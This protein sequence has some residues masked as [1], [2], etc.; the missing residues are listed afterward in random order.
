MSKETRSPHIPTS[1]KQKTVE[2]PGPYVAVVRE[3]LDV[4][5]MGSLKV[6]LLKTTSEGNSESSGEFVPVSYLSPFYGVT[7]YAGTSE[8]EGYDYTQKS[9]GFWAVPPDIGTKVLVIFAEGNRGKGYWIGCVQDQNMN[10]MVPGNASTKFNKED[11]TKARPVAEYNKKTEDANGTNATQYLKP[12]H[13]DACAILDGSGL[14]D[15]PIRGT[16]TSSAR[17]DLPSM[18]FGWSSPGPIDRR[19]GTPTIKSGGK[20]DSIDLKASRLTGTTLV[21]DDGDP[22]LFR[23]G[24]ARGPNAVPSEYVSLK[25]GGNPVLP[26]NEL[27]RIRTRTGHQILLHNA[28]DLIYIAHGSG[29]SWIEMTANGKIDIYSKDSIS[30][31]TEND[32]NFKAGRDVNIEAGNN[33]NLKAGNQMMTQTAANYEVK[34]GADGKITCAGT[35]NITSKHHYETA[36]RIDMNGPPAAKA[37]DTSV[38]TRVPKRGSW[39]GQENKN[40][41]EHTP[42]KTNANLE[43]IKK[44]NANKT[45][46]D[47][48]KDKKPEDTF[49]QC[50]VPAGNENAGI[51]GPAES[52]AAENKNATLVDD[53]NGFG[54]AQGGEF[55]TTNDNNGFGNSQDGEFGGTSKRTGTASLTDTEGPF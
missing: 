42:T 54:N 26:F 10:F 29:D 34:V 31:H 32:F 37:G 27:F 35:S 53:N 20:I 33:I 40:P 23:K 3:H 36:D 12:C 43:E 50:Q 19:D 17:R 7:P 11:P 39:T 28:E 8:N 51:D 55:D 6:E 45:S 44:G 47:K 46:D 4:D 16:T 5:Y 52:A 1:S 24:P 9:Y 15:D 13:T 22:T 18:V 14:A 48:S 49:K 30:I 38:P 21:M 25:D 2:G 41:L